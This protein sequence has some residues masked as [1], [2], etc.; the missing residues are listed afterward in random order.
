MPKLPLCS[1]KETIQCFQTIGY[2]VV[3][4]KGS[5]VRLHHISDRSKQPLTIPNHKV[6]GKGLL[7]KLLRDSHLTVEEFTQILKNI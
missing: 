2:R 4:Q 7:R 3:R 5:H 6:I 1:G